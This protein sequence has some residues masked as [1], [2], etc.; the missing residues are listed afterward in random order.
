M[1]YRIIVTSKN[2]KTLL[3]KRT[4]RPRPYELSSVKEKVSI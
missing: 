2:N 3:E 4:R 1:H